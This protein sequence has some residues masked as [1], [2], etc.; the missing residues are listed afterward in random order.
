MKVKDLSPNPKNPRT[1]T[2]AKLEQLKRAMLEF[3]DLS[4]IVFNRK[5][6]HLV[7][8]HQRAKN[9][10]A[11]AFV[12][13]VKTYKKPTKTGTIAEGHVELNGERFA[14]REVSWDQ[15]RERAANLA[16]NKGAGEWD[17]PQLN[18]WLKELGS[19]DV[20]FDI[21]LTMFDTDELKELDGIFVSEH[22]RALSKD[23]KPVKDLK[24]P[25]CKHGQVYLLGGT[26][27]RC[28]REELHFCDQII[29]RWERYAGKS[30]VLQVSD[31]PE[32]RT[33][34]ARAPVT[35]LR[36]HKTAEQLSHS[37]A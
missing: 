11:D 30:A 35:K 36:R 27:L 18:E 12:V 1:I 17:L 6:K 10:D 3:G 34:R 5:S 14:Y 28:S 37:D 7:G 15:N 8:A 20:D 2:D 21:G 33:K 22:T 25:K 23:G 26:R 16:A 13:I 29:A 24:P 9:L 31:E 32:K 19:F 4:G